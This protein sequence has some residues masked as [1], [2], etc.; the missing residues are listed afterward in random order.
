MTEQKLIELVAGLAIAQAKTDEHLQK[1]SEEIRE[2]RKSQAK[3]D[4]QMKKTDEKIDRIASLVGS[5]S[6][7]QG[8][9]AEEYFINSLG[10]SLRIGVVEFDYM[11]SN[12]K[13]KRKH[14]ILAECDIL[15]LN[16]NSATIIEVKYKAHLNDLNKLPK[17]IEQ[18]K[19][20]PD[21]K[22][23]KIYAG[24]ATFYATNEFI[25]SAKE[26]G[27]FVLQRRGDIIVTHFKDLKVA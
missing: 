25:N 6:N 23:R 17:K 22:N 11:I 20:L 10:E 12:F 15:L 18:L 27:Y 3:T 21:Y 2:L 5:I 8:N 24:V 14:Q 9:V 13:I 16:E 26:L 4:E 1:T 19:S 7:N